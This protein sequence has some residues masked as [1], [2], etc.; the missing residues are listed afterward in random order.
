MKYRFEG[1]E[2]ERVPKDVRKLIVNPG[3]EILPYTM[4]YER[5][6]LKEVILPQGLIK[7]ESNAFG[8]CSMLPVIKICCTVESIGIYAFAYCR[9]LQKVE[10]ELLSLSSSSPRLK[11]I[12]TSAF[13]MCLSLQRIKIPSSVNVIGKGAFQNCKVL[14]EAILC[15]TS[16]TEVPEDGF[17]EC[18]ALQTVSLPKSLERICFGAFS[19][20]TSLVTM[21]LPL[22]SQPIEI[23]PEAFYRCKSLSNVLL[24]KESNAFMS[25]TDCK[26]KDTFHSCEVLKRCFGDGGDCI[27]AGLVARFDNCPFHRLCYDQSSIEAQELCQ[28]TFAER[29]TKDDES[30]LVD[31]F[32]MTPFHIFFSAP[33]P[34]QDLLQVLLDKYP[35]H[36]GILD[37]KDANGKRPLDYLL[38]NWTGTTKVLFQMLLQ[39]WMVDP[40]ARWGTTSWREDMQRKIQTIMAGHRM[41]SLFDRAYYAFECYEGMGAMYI[42]EMALWKEKLKGERRKDAI[43]RQALDREQCRSVCGSNIVIPSVKTFLDI[44]HPTRA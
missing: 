43:K 1:N 39:R 29:T 17:K 12:N 13:T 18:R 23:G 44:N 37:C 21:I 4:C 9:Q 27:V 20:C 35:Y 5:D 41:E 7:I 34:C 32:G 6:M 40:L 2:G 16:I 3:V 31:K 38:S 11:T 26:R 25:P 33:E 42:L 10:F 28:S 19:R 14:V 22:D 30:S 15:T 36:T 24:P 8:K